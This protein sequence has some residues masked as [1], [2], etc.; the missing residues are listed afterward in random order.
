MEKTKKI[1]GEIKLLLIRLAELDMQIDSVAAENFA[2]KDATFREKGH[3]LMRVALAEQHTLVEKF[4]ALSKNYIDAIS[5]KCWPMSQPHN[6]NWDNL[7][8]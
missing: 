3:E 5:E 4:K 6:R 7:K 8:S 2:S 1:G